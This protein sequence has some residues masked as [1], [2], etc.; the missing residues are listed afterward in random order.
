MRGSCTL[1]I[2]IWTLLYYLSYLHCLMIISSSPFCGFTELRLLKAHRT[3]F[4]G[5]DHSGLSLL[6]TQCGG[7]CVSS[8]ASSC[9]QGNQ[10][11]ARKGREEGAQVPL[12]QLLHL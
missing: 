9:W 1:Q 11:T 2:H 7:H 4:N 12:A 3:L 10:I 8:L 5:N 6:Q